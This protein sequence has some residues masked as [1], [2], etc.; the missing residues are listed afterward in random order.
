MSAIASQ[1]TSLTI[2]YSI[3]YS[4]ADQRKHQSSASLAF[5]WGPV[6]SPH[7]C[8]VTRKMFP[9]VDV[10][11]NSHCYGESAQGSEIM[12]HVNMWLVKYDAFYNFQIQKDGAECH[13]MLVE[14]I[15]KG[16]VT[17][18]GSNDNN[19]TGVSLFDILFSFML[20]KCAV[21]NVCGLKDI[22]FESSSV[23][24]IVP[25]YTS[26]MQ[27]LTKQGMQQKIWKSFFRCKKNSW[28][29]KSNHIWQHTKYLIIIV[30]RFRYL[31]HNVSQDRCSLPMDKT[32]VLDFHKFSMQATMAMYEFW[33]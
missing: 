28:H 15:N 20:Q 18:Y 29:V 23:L 12:V 21:C 14:L 22:P 17:H 1:I 32:V 30:N 24:C 10:I 27:E 11:L 2:V 16:S 6:N 26:S 3:V 33:S 8:P 25:T 9:F 31:N 19:S 4:D 13:M 5:V 7:K